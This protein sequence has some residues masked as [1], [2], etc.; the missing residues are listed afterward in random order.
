MLPEQSGMGLSPAAMQSGASPVAP[1]SLSAFPLPSP[2]SSPASRSSRRPSPSP[3]TIVQ[4]DIIGP[5]SSSSRPYRLTTPSPSP[6]LSLNPPLPLPAQPPRRSAALLRLDDE[7]SKLQTK[8]QSTKN[9]IMHN[10]LLKQVAKLEAQRK[11]MEENG[12]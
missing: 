3:H 11:A 2:T 8:I 7:I 12:D 9:K 4:P 1:A 6:P 10:R 5:S